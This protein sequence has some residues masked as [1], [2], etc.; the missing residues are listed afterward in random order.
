MGDRAVLVLT[1][2]SCAA[3]LA[4]ALSRALREERERKFMAELE[5]MG[6]WPGRR[7]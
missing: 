2:V 5:H 3:V 6:T 1:A 4:W 7:T